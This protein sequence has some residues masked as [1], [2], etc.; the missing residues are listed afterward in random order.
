[1]TEMLQTVPEKILTAISDKTPLKRLG[2]P[3]DIANA[4]Y[5]LASDEAAFVTGQVLSVDG[6]LV[7]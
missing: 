3:E 2:K 4:Y 1:M 7:I 6:G 5:F